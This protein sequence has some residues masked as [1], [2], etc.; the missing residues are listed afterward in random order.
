MNEWTNHLHFQSQVEWFLRSD[1]R[2]EYQINIQL[3]TI[4][5]FQRNSENAFSKIA[6]SACFSSACSCAAAL[7]SSIY[8]LSFLSFF[9]TSIVAINFPQTFSA[10]SFSSSA[11]LFVLSNFRIGL[12]NVLKD[13]RNF[14]NWDRNHLLLKNVLKIH[15]T[16]K[17]EIKIASC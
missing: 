4:L 12:R 17:I 9:I 13:S 7:S 15:A 10:L 11:C 3:L 6:T 14:K 5:L 16:F 2:S 1:V 8:N